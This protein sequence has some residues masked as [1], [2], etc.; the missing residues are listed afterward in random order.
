[1]QIVSCGESWNVKSYFLEK[2]KKEKYFKML[3]AETI[4]QLAKC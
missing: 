3:S 1:M 4:T 2:K